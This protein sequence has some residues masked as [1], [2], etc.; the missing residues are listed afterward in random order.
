MAAMATMATM[1]QCVWDT[2]GGQVSHRMC[3]HHT[4]HAYAH[5]QT[6]LRSRTQLHVRVCVRVRGAGGR[7]VPRQLLRLLHL[8][9]ERGRVHHCV[10]SI[11]TFPRGR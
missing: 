8:G 11:F 5:L 7:Q 1:D 6:A 2:T 10:W 3:V 4:P 9:G